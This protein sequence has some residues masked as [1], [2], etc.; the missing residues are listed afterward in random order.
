MRWDVF[1]R[2]YLEPAPT[3]RV[4]RRLIEAGEIPGTMLDGWPYVDIDRWRIERTSPAADLP[5]PE[6]LR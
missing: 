4:G 2:R 6:L 3:K 1:A 5:V